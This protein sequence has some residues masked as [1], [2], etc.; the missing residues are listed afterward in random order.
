MGDSARAHRGR[1]LQR[2]RWAAVGGGHAGAGAEPGGV[3]AATAARLARA[4]VSCRQRAASPRSPRSRVG[5]ALEDFMGARGWQRLAQPG[6]GQAPRRGGADRAGRGDLLGWRRPSAVG[7]GV[8]GRRSRSD[9][10]SGAACGW[11]RRRAVVHGGPRARARLGATC[12]GCA[13][14]G[15]WPLAGDHAHTGACPRRGGLPG[16]PSDQDWGQQSGA[17]TADA[18]PTWLASLV[19]S[20]LHGQTALRMDRPHFP[21]PLLDESIAGMVRRLVGLPTTF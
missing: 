3:R 4:T 20:A 10:L 1:L 15:G 12:R 21:W 5:A 7:L 2:G 16:T 19:W 13:A 9:H 6:R 11:Y 17:A 18:D 14:P 8:R